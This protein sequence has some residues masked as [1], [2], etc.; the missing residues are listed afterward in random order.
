LSKS[1]NCVVS[2]EGRY[3]ECGL[4]ASLPSIDPRAKGTRLG[5]PAPAIGSAKGVALRIAKADKIGAN[6][7]SL[8]ESIKSQGAVT[9]REI[10]AA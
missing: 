7:L 2:I 6:L 8:I 5:S 9:Y 10:A 4:A 3:R 1:G